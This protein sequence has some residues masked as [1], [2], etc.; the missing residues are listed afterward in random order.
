MPLTIVMY[1]YV[2]DLAR[3]RYPAIKARTLEDFRGQLAHLDRHY[4]VV[5]AEQVMAAASGDEPLPDNACWLTFDDGY[6]DHYTNV[7]P[8]LYER[9][10]QGSFF[11]PAGPILD[12][13]LLDVN[14]IHLL[15]AAVPDTEALLG[16]L[17]AAVEEEREA[18]AALDSWDDY[19]AAYL[20]ECHLDTPEILFIKQMLQIALPEAVRNRICDRLFARFVSADEG[21]IAAETYLSVDQIR[22]MQRS[23]M[24]IGSH[25]HRHVWLSSLDR[26]GQA[27]EIDRSLAFIRTLGVTADQWIM[28][29]PYGGYDATTLELLAAK[30][31]ALGITTRSGVAE[32][33]RDAALELPRIDTIDLPVA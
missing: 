30:G 24:S 16:A 20:R 25:G 15:L 28:C 8:L 9:G 32:I 14:K 10:W 1:H 21:A 6:L 19:V 26:A 17:R 13:R 27:L 23:G 31:C 3:S 12:R 18:G 11:I 2:R 5:T 4:E 22:V 33:G 29:Y 7:F